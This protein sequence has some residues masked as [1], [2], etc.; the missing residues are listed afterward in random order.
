MHSM[1]SVRETSSGPA[2]ATPAVARVAVAGATGYTGQELL[3]ILSR[4]PSVR[5]TAATSSTAQSAARR[6]PA[7]AHLWDGAITPLDVDALVRDADLV[8][9]ALPDKAAAELAPVLVER[10]VRAVDLSG[11]FRLRDQA[12]RAQWYPETHQVRRERDRAR[13]ALLDLR[14]MTMSEDA[15]GR[16]AAVHFREVRTLRRRLAGA[17]DAGLGVDDHVGGLDQQAGFCERR[18]GQQ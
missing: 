13:E 10:G 1:P 14:A 6:L 18:Q 11:A 4:H 15:I 5:L 9:L 3:R 12:A 17:R 8:F 7:L 16:E 2:S